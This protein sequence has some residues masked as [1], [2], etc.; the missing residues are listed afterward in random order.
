MRGLTLR[1]A[2]REKT[3]KPG[4][5]GSRPS[6]LEQLTYRNLPGPLAEGLQEQT[7]DLALQ[8]GLPN[9]PYLAL[10]SFTSFSPSWTLVVKM[11]FI[12]NAFMFSFIIFVFLVFVFCVNRLE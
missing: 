8:V 7:K 5:L 4:L 10:I 12:F 1:E 6:S 2:Q 3:K 9:S 11:G